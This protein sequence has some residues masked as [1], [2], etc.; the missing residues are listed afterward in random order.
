MTMFMTKISAQGFRGIPDSLLFPRYTPD[1][2][3]TACTPIVT[4][5]T[6]S[7]QLTY[8]PNC[9]GS[10]GYTGTFTVWNFNGNTGWYQFTFL[11][12]YVPLI[13]FNIIN[14][15]AACEFTFC[16]PNLW[17]HWYLFVKDASPSCDTDPTNTALVE[18][19]PCCSQV[20]FLTNGSST[21]L[22]NTVPNGTGGYTATN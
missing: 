15:G 17:N 16:F 13:S 6:S 7:C 20:T 2:L 19:E 21:T 14:G 4:G 22:P 12:Y 3:R 11:P 18:M 1:A 8:D 10:P 5:P 9:F